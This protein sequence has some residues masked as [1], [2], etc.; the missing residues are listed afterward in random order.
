[1]KTAE[2]ETFNDEFLFHLETKFYTTSSTKLGRPIQTA[3]FKWYQT[4]A[5]SEA[6]QSVLIF[7]FKPGLPCFQ[8]QV[9]LS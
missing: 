3:Y 6:Y 9:N 4:L 1:M 2:K 5:R 7:F 8:R